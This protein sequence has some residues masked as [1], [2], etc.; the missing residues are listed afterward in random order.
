MT[1]YI[2]HMI[3]STLSFC[4]QLTTCKDLQICCSRA[5]ER[6]IN[7]DGFQVFNSQQTNFDIEQ[8]AKSVTWS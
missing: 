5:E 8:I 3:P 7:R 2:L 1:V 4:I 6:R